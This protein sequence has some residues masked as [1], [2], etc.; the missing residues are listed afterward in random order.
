M[1][2][3]YVLLAALAGGVLSV[4]AAGLPSLTVLARWAPRVVS[5]CVGDEGRSSAS[6]V[7]R[8]TAHGRFGS[9][10]AATGRRGTR[11]LRSTRR[12]ERQATSAR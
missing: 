6:P 8:R 10:A 2:L 4:A 7:S 9:G 3:A 5:V 11:A 1:T 12:F